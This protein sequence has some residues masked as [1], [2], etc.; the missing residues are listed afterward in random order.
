MSYWSNFEKPSL[1]AYY[2]ECF[3]VI[4]AY[5]DL[6]VEHEPLTLIPPEFETPLPHCQPAVFPPTFR[7]VEPPALELFNL[8]EEFSSTRSRLATAYNKC[9][10][11]DL[12]YFIEESGDICSV[13][14]KIG[15]N[16][17]EDRPKKILEYIF[18]QIVAFKKTGSAGSDDS[19]MRQGSDNLIMD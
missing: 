10:E 2:N 11:E 15:S 6:K 7:E 18:K 16:A 3:Q 13:L 17:P 12:Q 1:L 19:M 9:T 4:D 5:K 8:D 14:D